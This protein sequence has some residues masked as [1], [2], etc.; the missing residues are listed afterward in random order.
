ME[1]QRLTYIHN[2][3]VE[4]GFVDDP[5]AW[6]WSSC[7]SYEKEIDDQIELIYLYRMGADVQ[8]GIGS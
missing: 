2:N 7:A 5:T 1:C 8:R 4:A 6:V 3:P